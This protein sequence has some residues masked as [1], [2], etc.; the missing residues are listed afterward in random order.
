MSIIDDAIARLQTIALACTATT[1]KAAPNYPVMD[2]AVL[3]L[4]VAHI[5]AGTGQA[6]DATSARLLL[7][8][9]VD[10]H[11]NRQ[12]IKDAYTKIDKFIPEYLQ[13]LAGDPTLNG[14]VDTIVFP[15][16]FV[17]VPTQWDQ[18]T[19]Q[20]VSFQVPLKFIQTPTT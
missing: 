3:P 14:K 1:I 19:T 6:D 7:T 2:A 18:V 5:T 17:V 12:S 8:V 9:S 4:A 13:R 15:V 10:V 16:S 11:F 20:M